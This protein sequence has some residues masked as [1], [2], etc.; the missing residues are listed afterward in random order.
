MERPFSFD[1]TLH[2]SPANGAS[3]TNCNPPSSGAA[4][5]GALAY[6]FQLSD[7]PD[8]ATLVGQ[9]TGTARSYYA[10]CARW[11]AAPTTGACAWT[12]AAVSARGCPPG[13]SSVTPTT[14][15]KPRLLTPKNN[16]LLNDN[17]PTSAWEATI[18]AATYQVQID[19]DS[20]FGS[21]QQDVIVGGG[22]SPT[23]RIPS[24]MAGTTGGCAA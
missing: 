7:A 15:G 13:A 5:T 18:G 9:Y 1:L 21:P 19:D 14:P 24:P 6:D 23:W 16:A 3:T 11:W 8:F 4:W 2:A 20:A 12:P 17:T 10:A 22:C